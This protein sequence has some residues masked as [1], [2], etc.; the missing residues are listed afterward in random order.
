M[1]LSWTAILA[2]VFGTA[3]RPTVDP[4]ARSASGSGLGNIKN[5]VVLV[6]ENL[7]FD[8]IAGGLTYSDKIDGLLH[9]HYSNPANVT[10]SPNENIY[11]AKNTAPN[12]ASDD[13]NHSISGINMQIFG[14]YHPEPSDDSTMQGFLTEQQLAY[15]NDDIERASEV[16]NYFTPDRIPVINDLA[17]NYVL[18][19]HWFAAVPGPTNPNRAYL[20]SGTSDGH[21]EN[22]K[23]FLESTLTQT[24]IFEMLDEGGITWANYENSTQSDPPFQP[25]ALFYDYV[26]ANAKHRVHPINDFYRDA[27]A[28]NLPQFTWINPECCNYMS[29][30]PKSPVNMGENFV[31]GVYEALRGSPQWE[32]TLFILT[33]DEHGGFADHV[34]PRKGVPSGAGGPYTEKAPDG[35]DYTFHFDRLGV[36]VPTLLISPWVEKGRVEQQSPE[37]GK[38]YTHTSILKV[39]TELWGLNADRLGPRVKWSPSFKDLIQTTARKDKDLPKEISKAAGY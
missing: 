34:S 19:D 37:K 27:K 4:E 10:K 24:S 29:M 28:G 15:E 32:N 18:F 26:K 13:P 14:K 33:W 25:D 30:H 39:L 9:R 38:D 2:L 7:S 22:D 11:Y 35:K 36:R 12:V 20:T 1:P 23:A 21:G 16:L 17:Q 5:V 31:K 3:A 6:Q 8:H